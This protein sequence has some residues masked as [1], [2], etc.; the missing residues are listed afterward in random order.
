MENKLNS[1]NNKA[2]DGDETVSFDEL[3]HLVNLIP[4]P[5]A[6]VLIK[7]GVDEFIKIYFSKNYASSL[8]IWNEGMREELLEQLSEVLKLQK[9]NLKNSFKS[10][11]KTQ[12]ED[13]ILYDFKEKHSRIFSLEKTQNILIKYKALE[14]ELKA[15]PLFIRIWIME[16]SNRFELIEKFVS[17][18]VIQL[19][20]LLTIKV[21]ELE[22]N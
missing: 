11:D 2:G 10:L 12:Y 3:Y 6:H 7:E 14:N 4:H 9:N 5:L 19:Y 8:L 13:I 1:I 21:S 20:N 18:I 15:G 16:D 17:K 22:V